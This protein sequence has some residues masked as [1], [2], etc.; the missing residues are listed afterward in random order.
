MAAARRRNASSTSAAVQGFVLGALG[1][2]GAETFGAARC[3]FFAAALALPDDAPA[4][5]RDET[6]D[7][8]PLRFT[9][10]VA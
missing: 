3:F 5:A 4:E 9:F 6:R 1:F 10:A 8:T 2:A 7:E